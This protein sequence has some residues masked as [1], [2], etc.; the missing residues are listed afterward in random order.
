M[1]KNEEFQMEIREARYEFV[2]KE[3]YAKCLKAL[4][5]AGDIVLAEIKKTEERKIEKTN[6]KML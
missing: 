3:D 5:L 6:C 2:E 4:R 1:T